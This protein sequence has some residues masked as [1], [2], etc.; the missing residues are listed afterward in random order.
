ME[1]SN[2]SDQKKSPTRRNSLK[3]IINLLKKC[4]GFKSPRYLAPRYTRISQHPGVRHNQ[5]TH[6]RIKTRPPP[7]Q[8]LHPNQNKT[9]I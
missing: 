3:N 2:K 6:G 7:L 9:V 5:P 4:D 1:I 8:N